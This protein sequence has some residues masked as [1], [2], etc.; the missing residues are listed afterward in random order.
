MESPRTFFEDFLPSSLVG[1]LVTGL[2]SGT[3]VA[4]HVEG[5]DGGHW[6]VVKTDDGTMVSEVDHLPKD[7]ELWCSAETFMRIVSGAIRPSRAFLRGDLRIAGD[8]G[9]AMKMETILREAA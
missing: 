4:F 1:G 6:Q 5:S 8:V 9:L 3:V 2:P 7:C